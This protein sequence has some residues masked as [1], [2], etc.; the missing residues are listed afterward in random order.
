MI[1]DNNLLGE[2]HSDGI[3]HPDRGGAAV[4]AARLPGEGTSQVQDLLTS[5]S[6]GLEAAGE[7][8][9][10]L[11]KRNTTIPTEEGQIVEGER[12]M[13]KDRGGASVQA[14]ILTG[15]GSSRVQ[16]LLNS[17]QTGLKATGGAMSQLPS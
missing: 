14:T 8:M 15:E 17:L 2:F 16:D 7:V 10:K 1:K 6:V 4:Q 3:P 13:I 5:L 11:I 9:T 12:A